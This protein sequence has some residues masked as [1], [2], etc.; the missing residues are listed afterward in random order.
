MPDL[1]KILY[2]V[3]NNRG[4]A[5]FYTPAIYPNAKSYLFCGENTE[6]RTS[7]VTGIPKALKKIDE[8][9]SNGKIGFGYLTYEAGYFFEEMESETSNEQLLNFCIFNSSDSLSCFDSRG[10]NIDLNS[11]SDDV[12][13]DNF[14]INTSRNEYINSV[15]TIKNFIKEGFTYQVN[16]TVK[17][18][19]KLKADISKLFAS[20]IFQQS[21]EYIS[22]INTGENIIISFS[23]ELFFE[24]DLPSRN[25]TAKPMK[26]TIKR[27]I[28]LEQDALLKSELE[29]SVK[30]RAENIMIVDL[31]RNDLGKISRFNSIKPSSEFEIKNYE[32]L[33][34]M[35]TTV[36]G[37]L[38]T[39]EFSDIVSALFPCGS[40]TGAPKRKTM[41]IIS[42]LEK[43]SRGVYTGAIGMLLKDKWIFNVPIRTLNLKGKDGEIGI[44]SGIVWDSKAEN[45]YEEVLLKSD[46]LQKPVPEFRL[47][48]TMLLE[49]GKIF[50]EKEHIDRLES[51]ADFFLFNFHKILLTEILKTYKTNQKGS[52]K[53]RL[54]FD[55]QGKIYPEMK[56]YLKP[57]LNARVIIAGERISSKNKFYYFKTTNRGL[58]NTSLNDARLNGFD[59]IIFFNEKNELCEGAISNIVILIK[60]KLFTPTADS[61]LLNGTM[62]NKLLKN[63]VIKE[64]LLFEE[65]LI[66]A[67]SIFLIN[68]VFKLRRVSHLQKRD[69]LVHKYDNDAYSKFIEFETLINNLI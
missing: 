6:I 28:H 48:E 41:E 17:G 68:S 37:Q 55:K 50:L 16:F 49:D 26:G 8:E 12:L 33:F 15:N 63:G 24:V 35:V 36:T 42:M 14:F 5:F 47:I 65:D 9:I 69:G 52:Y 7:T 51:S 61:G 30:D 38:N 31:L 44:G 29:N 57:N 1:S 23:P 4:S 67:D 39:T 20:L 19:F 10:I 56:P 3:I 34:Q 59:E 64:K 40:I 60:G 2:Q 13:I 32:S 54:E 46:F 27:G 53:I 21:A 22:I 18:R 43:E 58:Y 45:E 11:S 62:R 25:I 66:N